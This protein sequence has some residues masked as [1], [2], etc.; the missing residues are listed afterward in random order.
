M[1][2]MHPDFETRMMWKRRTGLP[3][4]VAIDD[5]YAYDIQQLPFKQVAFQMDTDEDGNMDNWNA[6]GMDGTLCDPGIGRLRG[7]DLA[8][9]RGGFLQ[10]C[11]AAG[12]E[13]HIHAL[14]H[15]RLCAAAPQTFACGAYQRPFACNT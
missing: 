10:R 6:M 13:H 8:Q 14:T 1:K 12:I 4:N 15:Q 7:S 11:F 3:M 5:G 2:K 9:L